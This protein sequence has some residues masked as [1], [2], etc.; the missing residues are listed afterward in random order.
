MPGSPSSGK[1]FVLLANSSCNW[2]KTCAV[3]M[4]WSWAVVQPL[5]SQS[6]TI[7][8]SSPPGENRCLGGS[9]LIYGCAAINEK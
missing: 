9:A 2:S 3:M 4:H 8:C 1:P 6:R 7:Q 5:E